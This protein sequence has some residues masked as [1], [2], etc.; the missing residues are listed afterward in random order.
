MIENAHEL[1]FVCNL[2]SQIC[3]EKCHVLKKSVYKNKLKINL[4]YL[5]KIY[6]NKILVLR[7]QLVLEYHPLLLLR[8]REILMLY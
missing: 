4:Q 1:G 2:Y 8:S 6:K 5:S 3:K 7:F